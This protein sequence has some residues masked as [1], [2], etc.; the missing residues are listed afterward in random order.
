MGQEPHNH[1]SQLQ[2][3]GSSNNNVQVIISNDEVAHSKGTDWE[4]SKNANSIV[5]KKPGS[6]MKI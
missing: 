5:I 4:A 2:V 1:H 6:C 3:K